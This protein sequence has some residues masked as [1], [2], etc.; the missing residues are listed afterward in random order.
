MTQEYEIQGDGWTDI[1]I[2]NI[3]LNYIA[4]PKKLNFYKLLQTYSYPNLTN[5]NINPTMSFSL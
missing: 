4:W 5:N 1:L 2:A 3:A